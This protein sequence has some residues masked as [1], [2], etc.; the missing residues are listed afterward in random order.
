M[1]GNYSLMW[2]TLMCTLDLMT[3]KTRLHMLQHVVV[4]QELKRCHSYCNTQS[5]VWC[6][7]V[8]SN[9]SL[10]RCHLVSIPFAV[11]QQKAPAQV[12]CIHLLLLVGGGCCRGNGWGS[13]AG[14]TLWPCFHD[15][16]MRRQGDEYKEGKDKR[17]AF[18]ATKQSDK[19]TQSVV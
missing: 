19:T 17:A 8:L 12:L 1:A 14:H 4:L 2:L 16:L 5:L 11:A 10:W 15:T 13:D 9:S 18:S 3:S 7:N 6:V